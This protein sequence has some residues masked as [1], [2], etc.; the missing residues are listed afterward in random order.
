MMRLGLA[1]GVSLLGLTLSTG[2]DR[3]AGT[4][5]TDT[6]STPDGETTVETSKTIESSGDN[7]P[8]V[9]GQAVPPENP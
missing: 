7:P 6:V 1:I 4:T 3:E 5:R 2:C 9:N 8:P